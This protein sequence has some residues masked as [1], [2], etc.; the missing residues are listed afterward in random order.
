MVRGP[1]QLGPGSSPSASLGGPGAAGLHTA[2]WSRGLA[3]AL[4]LKGFHSQK[5]LR[6]FAVLKKSAW[7]LT[8]TD[9]MLSSLFSLAL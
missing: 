9:V 3:T 7:L 5:E 6:V 2:G 1:R 4:V 8:P